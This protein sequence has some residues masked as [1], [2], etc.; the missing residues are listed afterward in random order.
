MASTSRGCFAHRLFVTT[1]F[2]GAAFAISGAAPPIRQ[3][4]DRTTNITQYHEVAIAPSGGAVAWVEQSPQGAGR[5]AIYV[6][7]LGSASARRRRITASNGRTP[8]S[9]R[10]LAWSPDGARISFLSDRDGKPAQLFVAPA[11]GGAARKLTS[12]KGLITDPRWSP[13]GKSIAFL[14][15]A[16]AEGAAGPFEA[17]PAATGVIEETIVN[18]R[19]MVANP[20]TGTTR[21]ITP[22]DIHVYEYDWSPDSR[23][24]A[25]TAAPG[26]GDNNWYIAQLYTSAIGSDK[27]RPIFRPE[28]QIALPRWSPDGAS[29]AFI[30]GLMSDEGITGGN[31][32]TISVSGSDLRNRTAGRT[33]SPNWVA[34]LSPQKL[35]LTEHA[36]GGSAFATLDLLSGQ[37]ETTWQGTFDAHVEGFRGNMSLS[38]D[39]RTSAVIHST[40][41]EPPEIWAGTNG[42]WTAV[43]KA[44]AGVH[45]VWGKTESIE[46][47]NDGFRIQGW[48]MYPAGYSPA[49]RYPMVVFV[50]GGPAS[51][52]KTWWPDKFYDM[53][54]LSTQGYFVFFPNPRGSYGRGEEFTRANV[55]DFGGGDLRDIMAGV[56]EVIRTRPVDPVRLGIT[57]WS[58]GGYMTMWAIT[59]TNRFRAAVAGAGLANWQSY[60]GEN[61]IDQWMVPYFGASVYDDPAAYAKSSPITYIKSVKTPTLILVGERDGEC[62]TPQS[63]EYWHALKTLGVKTRLV[64]YPGEGHIF[65]KP[66]HRA[67]AVARAAEWFDDHLK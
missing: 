36:G 3:V 52:Q 60:Y 40:F 50:H 55:K 13:D 29:I 47:S 7:E 12:L 64:V 37:S 54:P 38:R 35:F 6:Q 67:D 20:E 43:T 51:I 56:D 10:S 63:Y 25:L 21:E 31:V 8:V 19:L 57:G 33:S 15:L 16:G 42:Q 66:E 53:S 39:G 14:F 1:L 17:V 34:W 2:A 26:P 58:Y 30:G 28:L 46:W 62:P 41:E 49:T 24:F 11:G 5:P 65:Q 61:S 23:S 22:A 27:L 44:N 48:L 59:Q 4:I 9:E 18:Q 32:Y 45:P